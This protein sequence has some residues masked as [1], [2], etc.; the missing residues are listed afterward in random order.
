MC[1]LSWKDVECWF[2]PG[3]KLCAADSNKANI[4]VSFGCNTVRWRVAFTWRVSAGNWHNNV[5]VPVD[6]HVSA[7]TTGY[8]QARVLSEVVGQETTDHTDSH[9]VF[10]PFQMPNI[11]A[12]VDH[13][14]LSGANR[15]TEKI[16]CFFPLFI[17]LQDEQFDNTAQIYRSV[18]E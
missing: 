4:I 7:N 12:T 6:K 13:S 10:L 5:E 15:F 18:S 14:Q 17:W 1:I 8:L 16:R 11:P 3:I 2:L 9:Q